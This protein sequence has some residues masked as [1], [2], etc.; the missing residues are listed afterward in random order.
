MQFPLSRIPATSL[1]M[2]DAPGAGAAFRR[3]VRLLAR[4]TEQLAMLDVQHNLTA[5]ARTGFGSHV[6]VLAA[7]AV[8]TTG[9]VLELGTGFYSTPL[10]HTIAQAAG[11]TR[12]IVSTDTD[13]GWLLLF[14][15]L[16]ASFHQAGSWND[17]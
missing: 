3:A 6:R 5:A 9:D 8:A 17:R 1:I 13:A 10:L 14:S 4:S 16:A 11:G 12:M 2:G 7:A 15:H